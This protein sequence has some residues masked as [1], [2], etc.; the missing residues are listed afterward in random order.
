M[1]INIRNAWIGVSAD[2]VVIEN[3][4]QNVQFDRAD[5]GIVISA[6]MDA[7]AQGAALEHHPNVNLMQFRSDRFAK[8]ERSANEP[9][10]A[11]PN[12]LTPTEILATRLEEYYR[13]HFHQIHEHDNM[14]ALQIAKTVAALESY[15]GFELTAGGE[16]RRKGMI[17]ALE[18]LAHDVLDNEQIA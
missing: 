15:G 8:D 16:L 12:A 5:L 7:K 13:E 18:Q 14:L 6:L 2:H 9:V 17:E 10:T 1:K 3:D 11:Q 4:T